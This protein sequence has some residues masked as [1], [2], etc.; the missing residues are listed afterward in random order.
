MVGPPNFIFW[1]RDTSCRVDCDCRRVYV[2]VR[3]NNLGGPAATSPRSFLQ[4]CRSQKNLD[5]IHGYH[6]ESYQDHL[7]WGSCYLG[8]ILPLDQK[9]N[10][11]SIYDIRPHLQLY[12]LP[13]IQPKS[14]SNHT[15]SL[16]TQGSTIRD[17]A[18]AT[19]KGRQTCRSILR[20]R[21]ER[22]R[23]VVCLLASNNNY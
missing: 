15:R 1:L 9:I 4:I 21:M 12:F 8:H 14:Q 13:Q 19:G 22:I 18:R 11:R 2:H 20:W 16:C 5:C 23:C 3:H 10:V 17:Q 7:C 6:Q